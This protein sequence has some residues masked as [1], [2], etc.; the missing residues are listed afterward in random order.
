[1]ST[2]FYVMCAVS[3]NGKDGS[4]KEG[5]FWT[6]AEQEGNHFYWWHEHA[7]KRDIRSSAA[8]RTTASVLWSQTLVRLEGHE[9]NIPRWHAV[10]GGNGTTW[11]R[12][13]SGHTTHAAAFLHTRHQSV[14]WWHN[15]PHFLVA[16]DD[17]LAGLLSMLS[18]L[19]IPDDC[20]YFVCYNIVSVTL[21]VIITSTV[22][23]KLISIFW[24]LTLCWCT[25]PRKWLVNISLFS[26]CLVV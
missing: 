8:D 9:Q 4:S 13:Q 24:L 15:G 5:L 11:W 19:Y 1:M 16:N 25:H 17:L 21:L 26:V 3:D 20:N 12:P 7:S 23:C 22:G 14:Q 18:L 2:D 10:S 6:A